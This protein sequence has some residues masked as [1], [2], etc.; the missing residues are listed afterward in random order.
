MVLAVQ[1]FIKF[2]K[3][4]EFT[5]PLINNIDQQIKFAA[6]EKVWQLTTEDVTSDGRILNIEGRQ[7]INFALHSYLGLETDP[8]VKAAI[9]DA[10]QNFGTSYSASRA[11]ISAPQYKVLEDLLSNIFESYPIIIPSTTLAH[12][13][14]FPIL[15]Q[16]NDWVILDHFAHNSVRMAAKTVAEKAKVVTVPHNDMNRLE[17]MIKKAQADANINNI[18]YL[19]DG[20]YSMLGGLCPIKEL[21]H[22]LEKY[23]NF[24]TYIDDAH[25]MSIMGKNGRGYALGSFAKQPEK[26][27]VAVGFAKSFGMGFGSA[28]VLPNAEWQ[29][30][31]KN[32]GSTC[33]FSGPIPTPMLSAGIALAKI[34]LSPEIKILQAKLKDLIS[35]YHLLFNDGECLEVRQGKRLISN[36]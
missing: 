35:Y 24:Y 3:M 20:V 11:F 31:I 1:V 28:I 13:A 32:C 25:G 12:L 30:K 5:A 34:H 15:I 14:A 6:Q 26:M 9:I 27:V 29:Q 8:R 36:R 21:N 18:W 4:L 2:F 23:N 33:L 7:L 10:A 19:A 22:L 17:A 16:K